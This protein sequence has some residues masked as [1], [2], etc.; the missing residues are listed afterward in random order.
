MNNLKDIID[1][2]L[3]R[4]PN[5]QNQSKK[6]EVLEAWPLVVG[7]AIAK[8]TRV[9]NWYSDGSLLIAATSNIWVHNLHYLEPQIITKF[10]DLLKRPLVKQLKFKLVANFEG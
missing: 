3:K 9:L 6:T 2:V 5:Y 7:E 8:N 1:S 10:E 4:T